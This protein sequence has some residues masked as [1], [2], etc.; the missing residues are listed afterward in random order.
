MKCEAENTTMVTPDLVISNSQMYEF[1]A[2]I[3][4]LVA[5]FPSQLIQFA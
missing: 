5:V 2:L 4:D 3:K 1:L